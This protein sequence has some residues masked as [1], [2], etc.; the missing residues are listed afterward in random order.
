[1][2]NIFYILLLSVTIACDDQIY[3]EL[4]AA[5]PVLVIDAWVNNKPENQ[6]IKLTR[7][8]PYLADDEAL[9]VSGAEVYIT[10]DSGVR[11]DFVDQGKGEYVW[12]YTGQTLG[13]I[14]TSFELHVI[15]N[16]STYQA[17]SA[18]N[19]VPKIDSVTFRWQAE[20]FGLPESYF[21]EFWSRDLEGLGDV[22]WIKTYK[23]EQ[24][25]NKPS[26]INIAYDA[27][28]S[29]GGEIDNLIFIP[30]IRD[31]INP[32]DGDPDSEGFLSPYADGDSLYVEIYSL[33]LAAH[34]FLTEV[35]IQT[36]RPGGFGE[37]FA[38]PLSN[39]DVNI[40]NITNGGPVLGFFCV[41]AVEANGKRLDVNEV[42]KVP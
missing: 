22:Y 23:N 10:D 33:T 19:R 8:Q 6:S 2:K 41:S 1:M 29:A 32:F 4:G 37:L 12:P 38:T 26:E 30:P 21:G 15:D 27:G 14:G 42:P 31:A 3:P 11:F 24:F 20:H 18:M 9:V 28:F 25:L 35:K 7:S 17:S 40:E 34:T 39:V 36:D 16:G 13:V 5:P